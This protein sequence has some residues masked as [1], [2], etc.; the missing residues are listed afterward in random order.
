MFKTKIGQNFALFD[1][2]FVY[3]FIEFVDAIG[4]G[5]YYRN[6]FDQLFYD[7]SI[8][9]IY[10]MRHI[11]SLHRLRLKNILRFDFKGNWIKSPLVLAIFLSSLGVATLSNAQNQ[12]PSQ[13]EKETHRCSTH[14]YMLQ[15]QQI[16]EVDE[17]LYKAQKATEKAVEEYVSARVAGIKAPQELDIIFPVVV[18]ILHNNANDSIGEANISEEQVISQI[19]RL[20]RDFAGLNEE[21]SNLPTSFPL[22][23]AELLAQGSGIQFCLASIDPDGNDT[24]GIHRVYTEKDV[25]SASNNNSKYTSTG[26]TDVWPRCDYINIWVV[27]ALSNS[28]GEDVLGYAQLPGGPSNTDGIVIVNK[29][30]G[31]DTGTSVK[32][33]FPDINH[34]YKGRTLVHE[35]GHYFGLKHIWGDDNGAC[36]GSDDVADTPNQGGPTSGCPDFSETCE[37]RDMTMNFLDYTYD[38]C[39]Y[40]F[41]QG[42]IARM[43]GFINNSGSRSCLIGAFERSCLGGCIADYGDLTQSTQTNVCFNGKSTPLVL[44]NTNNYEGYQT[45]YIVKSEV[46]PNVILAVSDT[47]I[48]DFA[49]YPV[50]SY[51]VHPINFRTDS[52]LLSNIQP[53][54]TTW[55]GLKTN[56]KMETIVQIC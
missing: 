19:D 17:E 42:Q 18:H 22:E 39:L 45:R 30:F 16:I 4:L 29:S 41:T 43:E 11:I 14:E 48:I 54:N 31:D 13:S 10:I 46:E 32:G 15:T 47:N 38:E 25:F 52:G 27:P 53:N 56:L 20:N 28:N 37:N 8:I 55:A 36:T 34:F 49:G 40:M 12:S 6:C 5:S 21:L 9:Y 1:L 51:G 26:G 24:D 44:N 23:F 50:G 35:M 7:N 2:S 3:S 33:T